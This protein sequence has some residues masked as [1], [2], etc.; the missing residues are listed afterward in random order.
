[1][2]ISVILV[3]L[4]VEHLVEVATRIHLWLSVWWREFFDGGTQILYRIVQ[5][6]Q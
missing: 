1:M 6:E 5:P 3:R 2:E 4:S